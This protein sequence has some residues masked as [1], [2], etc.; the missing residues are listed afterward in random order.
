MWLVCRGDHGAS[1][2]ARRWHP[3]LLP[4]RRH[5]PPVRQGRTELPH[6]LPLPGQQYV[7]HA[8]RPREQRTA[9][10]PFR[11]ALRC[12]DRRRCVVVE[13]PEGFHPNPDGQTNQFSWAE[14][15]HLKLFGCRECIAIA[16][17]GLGPA[18]G[19]AS[20]PRPS[21]SA[22]GYCNGR[23]CVNQ[24]SGKPCAP[25]DTLSPSVH[26]DPPAMD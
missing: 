24:T 11:T 12:S 7:R 18:H 1:D 5:Q 6:T 25:H 9:C 15:N 2:R 21:L 3:R 23:N 10:K 4:L 8:R 16:P 26:Q 19:L 22:E 14:G 17:T 20:Y 13:Q